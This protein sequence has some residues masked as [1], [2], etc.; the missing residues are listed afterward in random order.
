MIHVEEHKLKKKT[1]VLFLL[2]LHL[3]ATQSVFKT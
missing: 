2:A 3:K 1:V